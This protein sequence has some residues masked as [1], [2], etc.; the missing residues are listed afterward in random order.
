[1][2]WTMTETMVNIYRNNIMK[3]ITCM[4]LVCLLAAPSA[5]CADDPPTPELVDKVVAESARFTDGQSQAPLMA[6]EQLVNRT[7]GNAD[8][9]RHLELS[10][11][12]LL[13]S[14]ATAPAKQCA[15]H[16]LWRI[17]TDA[18]LPALSR[19][20]VGGDACLAEAACYAI[21]NHPS[22]AAD[23]TLTAA[24]GT[25]QGNGL[26]AIINLTAERRIPGAA[27][28]LTTLASG[29][30]AAAASAATAALGK[31]ATPDAIAALTGMRSDE[32]AYALL[33]A[34]RELAARGQ[35]ADAWKLLE[36]LGTPA[37]PWQIR[38]GALVGRIELGG[39]ESVRLALATLDTPDAVFKPDVIAAT[40]ALAGGDVTDA[41]IARLPGLPADLQVMMIQALV[42]RG[43]PKVCAVLALAMENKDASVRQAAIQGLCKLGDISP[44]PVPVLLRVMKQDP[45]AASALC[46]MKAPG[47]DR[48]IM[49]AFKE[50]RGETRAKL[51]DIL[52][53]R[54]CSEAA[55]L[56]V[57]ELASTDA[58]LVKAAWRAMNQLGKPEQLPVM[59][60]Q[61]AAVTDDTLRQ[62]A[63][64]TVGQLARQ[65]PD[66]QQA[67]DLV[68]AF[69]AA[70]D[71]GVRASLLRVLGMIGNR[72][73]LETVVGAL[74]SD[75][76]AAV[77]AL[78]NWPNAEAVSPLMNLLQG[79]AGETH[80]KLAFEGCLGRLRETP[81][82]PAFI[83][84]E[85]HAKTPDQLRA[86]LGALGK[87]HD[88]KALA[89]AA[90][91]LGNAEVRE[92]AALAVLAIAEALDNKG[93]D[94]A[95]ATAHILWIIARTTANDGVR[96][97]AT[98]LADAQKV[99]QYHA[100]PREDAAFFNGR[101]LTGWEP[102][103]PYWSVQDGAITGS[104]KEQVPSNQFIWSG[105]EVK[106]FHL[107]LDVKLVPDTGNGG[108]QFRSQKKPPTEAQGY[109][110]DIGRG[111]WGR[112]YHESSGRGFIGNGEQDIEAIIKPGAWNHYEILA[113]G[114]RIWLA[115]NGRII[116][117]VE[118]PTGEL[119]GF[120]AVQLHAGEPQSISY[121]IKK[122]VHNP[123]VALGGMDEAQLNAEILRRVDP[124]SARK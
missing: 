48:A 97:R 101:D 28:A 86:L 17:G 1:M 74:R 3:I 66:A 45:L 31:I 53:A 30:D 82:M 24:L 54:R 16:Q 123:D 60:K 90:R 70:T 99:A 15:C 52:A 23:Q 5:R 39:E 58:A 26:L 112:L 22:P 113:V 37:L 59:V 110:A 115:M 19:L 100:T 121:Q 57:G 47:T 62:S 14:D 116:E 4:F 120:I 75:T 122:M 103:T 25:A 29:N 88:I 63:E 95:E 64:S 76:D 77:R 44:A 13:E 55:A 109:Q 105:V 102:V 81:S 50:A 9:R 32:A 6:L 104:G 89:M 73:A 51:I 8:L 11:V 117:A 7:H 68:A 56:L 79:D 124:A 119:A 38:R 72:Q 33:Q 106:D 71:S 92:E 61:L 107:T 12:A 111:C 2:M 108:I 91:H 83:R 94:C 46:D 93:R 118:D 21:S 87:V 40:A 10:L 34:G 65:L 85:P 67:G 80:K 69:A 35:K 27:P 41:L 96:E 42:A 18:S 98:K 78:C 36:K 114:H 20:M 49:E 84:L 43:D